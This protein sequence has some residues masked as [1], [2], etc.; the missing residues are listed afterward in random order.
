MTIT[1]MFD[2]A[3]R[4]ALVPITG[5]SIK[6]ADDRTTWRIDYL[7]EA[8]EAERAIGENLRQTYDMDTDTAGKDEVAQ[9][10]YD[11]EKLLQ[12]VAVALWECIPA[13]TMTKAQLKARAIAIYRALG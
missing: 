4:R 1:Y 11:A 13:P 6:H 2:R 8:T 9:T 5:V 3:L 10:R 7:P 12:A